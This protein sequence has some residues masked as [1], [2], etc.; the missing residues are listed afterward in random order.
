VVANRLRLIVSGFCLLVA[1]VPASAQMQGL[2]VGSGGS[3]AEPPRSMGQVRFGSAVFTPSVGITHIG[4]DRN[5]FNEAGERKSDFTFTLGPQW[6]LFYGSDRLRVRVTAGVGYVYYAKYQ[7]ER[8]VNPGG[9]LEGMYQLGR[10]VTLFT[11]DR[12]SFVK[13]RPNAEV[14]ARTRRQEQD[15][16]GGVRVG[17]SPRIGVQ[18]D[19]HELRTKYGDTDYMGIRLDETLDRVSRRSALTLTYRLTPYTSV[20]SGVSLA[21]ER[22][23]NAGDRDGTTRGAFAGLRFDKR[24]KVSGEAELGYSDFDAKS[25]ATN[26]HHGMTFG[27]RLSSALADSLQL[28]FDGRQDL[29]FSYSRIYPYYIDQR[30]RVALTQRLGRRLDVSGGTQ[31]ESLRYGGRASSTSGSRPGTDRLED[32][33]GGPGFTVRGMRFGVYA[34]YSHRR[35]ASGVNQGYEGIRYGVQMSVPR[36]SVSDNG[37]FVNSI[38]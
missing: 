3:I 38:R 24:A 10:R 19:V 7:R 6:A 2:A 20:F 35:V 30:Y 9:R 27:V 23:P 21:E 34:G 32:Y 29:Q 31:Q 37:V 18:L 4:V 33:S 25:L 22:V 36:L 28:S 13:D 12:F 11:D 14:D 15:L 1:V 17:L 5:V 16:S 26:D 8:G